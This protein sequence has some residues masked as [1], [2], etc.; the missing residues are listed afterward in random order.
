[1]G[2]RGGCSYLK[3]FILK[4]KGQFGEDLLALKGLH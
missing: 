1:M 4:N 3:E 2:G